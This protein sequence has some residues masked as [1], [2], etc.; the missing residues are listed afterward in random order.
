MNRI[1]KNIVTAA[2][3][4]SM[5]LAIGIPSLVGAQS[6]EDIKQGVDITGTESTSV[7]SAVKATIDI[8]SVVVGVIAVIMII[9]GGLK[10]VT[11]NGD[12]NSI[13]SAKN[14][15]IY[16]LIGIV[17]VAIAQSVVRFVLGKL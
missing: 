5:V 2:V 15:I 12:S 1:V 17:V 13:S 14:T 10:Y 11:S 9:I 4:L 16:A 3:S 8:L 7:D 6:K